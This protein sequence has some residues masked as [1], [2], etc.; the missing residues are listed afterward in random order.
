[1]VQEAVCQQGV[2]GLYFAG[3]WGGYGFHEDGLKAGMEVAQ[4]LGASI[5]WTPF[6]T[7]PKISWSGAWF[8]G[9]FGRFAGGAIRKGRLVIILPNGEQRSYG[10]A[11]IGAVVPSKPASSSG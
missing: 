9:V 1:M 6:S 11:S 5:P 10:A 7:S 3:A 8:A 4:A 2:D